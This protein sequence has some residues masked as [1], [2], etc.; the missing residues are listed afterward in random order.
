MRPNSTYHEIISGRGGPWGRISRCALSVM[1]VGYR[2]VVACRNSRFDRAGSQTHALTVPVISVGNITTGGTGKT[3]LVI[4]LMQRLVRS[5]R[6]AA[7][8]SRGYKSSRGEL[9]DELTMISNR[10]PE[11]ICIANP[12]R[13]AGGLAAV[14]RGAEVVVLD[15]GFQHRRLRRDLDIVVIDATNPFGF[16]HLLPRG[17]L[18]EP[19]EQLKRAD[20]IVVSRADLVSTAALDELSARLNSYAPNAPRL[21]CRHKPSGVTNLSGRPLNDTFRRAVVFG[22][23]GNPNAF[24]ATIEGMGIEPVKCLWWQDHHAYD[25]RDIAKLANA[26]A[27]TDHDVVLTTC[28]DA[29]KL[30]GLRL[31]GIRRLGVVGI[32]V[33]FLDG[34][35]SVIESWLAR[36]ICEST[37]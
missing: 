13:V 31:D 25:Q 22:A 19:I 12:D 2:N 30:R 1:S 9:G 15:D 29:V 37:P 4:D 18:R 6:R 35:E 34:G 11:A 32:D 28:K 21:S 3:P 27:S 26:C 16:G 20:V 36:V 10:V 17:L 8:V 14:E 7:V 33:E 23:I 5:G 24:V